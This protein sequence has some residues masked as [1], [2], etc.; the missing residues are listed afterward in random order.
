MVASAVNTENRAISRIEFLLWWSLY[1][2]REDNKYINTILG[3]QKC[4]G[5]KQNLESQPEYLEGLLQ[6]KK[7]KSPQPCTVC[8]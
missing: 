3:I 6:I 7:Y 4:C 1:S 2:S 8:N 5:R